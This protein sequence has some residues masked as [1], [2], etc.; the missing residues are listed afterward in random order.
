[1]SFLFPED[2][3][4]EKLEL[5]YGTREFWLAYAR[6][7]NSQ[8]WKKLCRQVRQRAGNRCE[9]TP[10]GGIPHLPKLSVHHLTY[11]RFRNERL[12]DLQ[13]LCEPC[14]KMADL[15]REKRNREKYK[16]AGEAGR[17]NAWLESFLRTK[18]GGAWRDH[19]ADDPNGCFEE[20]DS[21][22]EEKSEEGYDPRYD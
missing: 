11:D 22:R 2:R 9:R 16:A 4:R 12:E 5:I 6:Y 13:L 8:E 7:I 20:F 18:Y 17:E 10:K 14:H 15:E 19:L 3:E 21:W 1:V